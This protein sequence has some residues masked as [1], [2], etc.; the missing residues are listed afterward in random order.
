MPRSNLQ[1]PKR[2]GTNFEK[3]VVNILRKAF[4][5]SSHEYL[6]SFPDGHLARTPDSGAGPH[7]KGDII[8]RG[9]MSVA[10]PWSVECKYT[11]EMPYLDRLLDKRTTFFDNC[12]IQTCQSAEQAQEFPMLVWSRDRYPILCA[13]PQMIPE[14]TGVDCP[15][16]ICLFTELLEGLVTEAHRTLE[17]GE[18]YGNN[19]SADGIQ[20][21]VLLGND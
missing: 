1:S 16:L 8:K 12:W 10:F 17:Y 13:V 14:L 3:K 21:C 7:D 15:L 11:E 9:K 2:K 4:R 18:K 19:F 20:N 6:K 5:E